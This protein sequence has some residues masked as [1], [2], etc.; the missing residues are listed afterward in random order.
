MVTVKN[1]HEQLYFIRVK[2]SLSGLKDGEGWQAFLFCDLAAL[3]G[4][5]HIAFQYGR[6]NGHVQV[7]WDYEAFNPLI[8]P[9]QKTWPDQATPWLKSLVIFCRGLLPC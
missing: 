8:P 2:F 7:K 6:K 9:K 3:K 5:L 4:M 1:F